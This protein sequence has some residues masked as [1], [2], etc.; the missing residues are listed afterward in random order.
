MFKL[1]KVEPLFS[2][3]CSLPSPLPSTRYD[4]MSISQ[5]ENRIY[6]GFPV[7]SNISVFD[8]EGDFLFSIKIHIPLFILGKLCS[9][10]SN[11][12]CVSNRHP[13]INIYIITSEGE[14]I[15]KL[16]LTNVHVRSFIDC[17]YSVKNNILYFASHYTI[18]SL[19]DEG[20]VE[21]KSEL[22]MSYP[23]SVNIA[24]IDENALFICNRDGKI[25]IFD[26]EQSTLLREL[27]LDMPHRYNTRCFDFSDHIFFY[28][29][30][31][32][33][34]IDIII[35]SPIPNSESVLDGKIIRIS[36]AD[37]YKTMSVHS[38][39]RRLYVGEKENRVRVYSLDE[40]IKLATKTDDKII[41]P[42][43]DADIHF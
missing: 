40:I 12:L 17:K 34:Y 42:E 30:F 13:S 16:N 24:C 14:V 10:S 9:L 31:M 25:S 22:S 43:Q 26:L 20:V 35:C 1:M 11:K 4:H 19:G 41:E 33:S 18:Y 7:Y 15:T 36:I 8:L 32:R 23:L 21:L 38:Q 2:F 28:Y 3:S 39:T 5:E 29:F 6:Y 27:K 37:R